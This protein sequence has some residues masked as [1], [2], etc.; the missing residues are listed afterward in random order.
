MIFLVFKAFP[1]KMTFWETFTPGFEKWTFLKC[2]ILKSDPISFSDFLG[3]PLIISLN[4]Y[5]SRESRE[6]RE[7][8]VPSDAPSLSREMQVS[9]SPLIW[10]R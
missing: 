7:P 4:L 5:N 2:P 6:S 10:I 8:T 1:S 9:A 3:V